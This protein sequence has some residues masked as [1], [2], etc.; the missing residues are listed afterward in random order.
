MF[1]LETGD[2]RK[3]MLGKPSSY[4]QKLFIHAITTIL[5]RV[6]LLCCTCWPSGTNELNYVT[7]INCDGSDLSNTATFVYQLAHSSF[8]RRFDCHQCIL[9]SQIGS[10]LW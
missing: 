6:E 2:K 9:P 4:S 8:N 5:G 1:Y 3:V 7:M 10:I